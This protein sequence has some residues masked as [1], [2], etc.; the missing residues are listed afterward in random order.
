[1]EA[2]DAMT[3]G[4]ER[5]LFG[6]ILAAM[7]SVLFH[8]SLFGG[9]ILSPGD[10]VYTMASFE[11]VRPSS[12]DY[13]PRNRLRMDPGLQFQPW[14]EF[15]RSELRAG[16]LP[17]WN[18][19][20]GCGAP[21]LA[22]GQSAV[23]DPFHLIAYAGKLPDAWAWMALARLWTAG[24]GMFLLSQSWGLSRWGR[25]FAGLSF[26]MCGFLV[27]WLLYPVANVAIWLPWLFW[28]TDRVLEGKRLRGVAG[29]AMV[30]A[31][32]MLGGHVQTSAHVLLAAGL[33]VVWRFFPVGRASLPA[34]KYRLVCWVLGVTVGLSASAIEFVPL[35]FYLAKSP[36]WSDR[37]AERVPILRVDM[38]RVLDATTTAFPYALG[39]QRRGHPN[40]AKAL[41]VHNLNE[42]AG[43]FAGLATL[44]WLAP[45]AWSA[46][47][48]SPR[49]RFL[50]GL[51]IF[52]AMAAFGVF[53]VPNLLRA[54]PVLDVADHRRMTLWVAFALCLLGGIGMDQIGSRA[55]SRV[56]IWWT[57]GWLVAAAVLVVA[58]V[59]IVWAEPR[60]R[61]KAI[62]HYENAANETSGANHDAYRERALR[63]A[64]YAITFL[65]RYYGI[66]AGH[67]ALL[68]VLWRLSARQN[69]TAS[70][71]ILIRASVFAIVIVD[72]FA[73]GFDLNPAIAREEDRPVSA[74]IAYLRREVAP[75]ARILAIG[76]E[77]PPNLL[78]RYGLADVRN[79][80]SVEMSRSLAWFEDLY[81]PDPDRPI[82]TSR[83]EIT[84]MRASR[85]LE[86]LQYAGVT[87]I[88]AASAPPEGAF[89]R[90]DR[91]GSVWVARLES[92]K[93]NRQFRPFPGE[94]RIDVEDDRG[95][96]SCTGET[97]DLGWKAEVD[98]RPVRI[99][100]H[101]GA[102]LSANAP[103]GSSRL[104][105]RY[106]PWDVR[107]A[108]GISLGGLAMILVIAIADR[109]IRISEGKGLDRFRTSG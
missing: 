41:G 98:G 109:I 30:V 80:D 46:R 96:V 25:W 89:A 43:G 95:E 13:E 76:A 29:L 8:A 82:H 93:K 31:L 16:R 66:A 1:M 17:L 60:I 27:G 44:I 18:P 62:A 33:Y 53:P 68:F 34:H 40:L 32:V 63:Q 11:D 57:R 108:I 51:G 78:M 103:R 70:R 85:G 94:I 56:W 14:L 47:S 73:F 91:V 54:L 101:L 35:A 58:A 15:N 24:F 52:G 36:A 64:Y 55:S 37:K 97:F 100:A 2:R 84:W 50:A 39:S 72:L 105:F 5:A 6:V 90:V 28:A 49:V 21:H 42:S 19:Y 88:V 67:L 79:Y 20:A 104:V 69:A 86:R 48:R 71:L 12:G 22:N 87:A 26:P 77:L 59:A 3:T 74:V 61:E 10:V 92:P 9:K 75:P 99:Q 38:P 45:A 4:R 83:R 65:P 23:F 106:D 107:V 102:F 7:L 81:E